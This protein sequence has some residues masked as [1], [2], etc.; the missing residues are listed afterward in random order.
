MATK[1]KGIKTVAEYRRGELTKDILRLVAAGVVVGGM[2]VAAP[3]TVQLIDYLNPKGVRERKR[4]WGII[5]YLEQKN[6][7]R[8]EERGNVQYVH[9]TSIGELKLN[10]ATVW[11][12]TIRQPHHWD[13]KWRIVMFDLPSKHEQARKSFRLKLEDLGFKLYQRS[14]F[15]YPHECQE[16]VLTIAKWYGIDEHIR[17]IVATE[18]HDTRKFVKEFDLL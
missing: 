2:A 6:R 11:D 1:F 5:K 13:R 14:V 8:I 10:E 9:L 16:E 3:N 17:Y 18:I 12:I 4:I 7:I 15:I